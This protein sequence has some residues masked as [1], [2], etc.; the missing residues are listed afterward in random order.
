MTPLCISVLLSLFKLWK[1]F[2]LPGVTCAISIKVYVHTQNVLLSY[3]RVLRTERLNQVLKTTC[4]PLSVTSLVLRYFFFFL[5]PPCFV[6]D[7]FFLFF[8]RKNK[9]Q[10][11]VFNFSFLY[12]PEV[13]NAP[14][15]V[16]SLFTK[17]TQFFSVVVVVRFCCRKNSDYVQVLVRK[18]CG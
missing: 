15:K 5:F 11:V 2:H 13:Q 10:A 6:M 8:C 9:F 4:A 17:N 1:T 14:N 16:H 18:Q 3:S 7:F 12:S